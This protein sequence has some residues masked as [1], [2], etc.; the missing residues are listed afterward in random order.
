[1]SAGVV[2]ESCILHRLPG[3]VRIRLP[4]WGGSGKRSIESSL[5]AAV[6]ITGAKA[7]QTTRNV[8][9]DFDPDAIDES[10]VLALVSR[11]DTSANQ[12]GLPDESTQRDGPRPLVE[13]EAGQQRARIAVRGLEQDLR[14]ASRLVERLK[15]L[16]GVSDAIA[17]PLTGRV[18]VVFDDRQISL[19]ALRAQ[20]YEFEPDIEVEREAPEHPLDP[21]PLV[22]SASR[23]VGAAVGLAVLGLRRLA[24]AEAAAAGGPAVVVSS[25]ISLAEGF[26]ASRNAVRAT[27]GDNGAEVVFGGAGVVALTLS[28]GPLGLALAAATG[29]RTL[30]EL[31]GRRKGFEAYEQL[32]GEPV[33]PGQTIRLEAGVRAPLAGTIVSGQGTAIER[34]GMPVAIGPS[35]TVSAGSRMLGGPFELELRGDEPFSVVRRP[36]PATQTGPERYLR[37]V[38]RLS[39]A[40]A[41]ATMLATGS[42]A[43]AFAALIVVNPRALTTGSAGA[44]TDALARAQRSGATVIG[45]RPQRSLR[46]PDVVV[47]DSPRLV[48]TGWDL[49]EVTVPDGRLDSGDALAVASSVATAA[50]SPWGDVLS[51]AP[52]HGVSHGSFENGTAS[53][54]V[55][56]VRYTLEPVGAQALDRRQSSRPDAFVL[57]LHREGGSQPCATLVLER[58]LADGVG[59]LIASCRSY[60]VSVQL[61][62]FG[63]RPAAQAV[64][65]ALGASLCFDQNS[66]ELIRQRQAEGKRVAFV[67]DSAHAAAGFAACD[68]A[69]GVGDRASRFCARADLLASDLRTVSQ[70]IETGRRRDLAVRDAAV[71]SAASATLGMWWAAAKAPTVRAAFSVGSIPALAAVCASY[72]RLRGPSGSQAQAA[73]EAS[74]PRPERWGRMSVQGVVATLE[75]NEGGLTSAEAQA[76]EHIEPFRG[77]EPGLGRA[78]MGQLRSPATAVLGA[79]AALSLALGSTADV[80]MVGAVILANACVEAWQ[81][82]Q[83]NEASQTLEQLG[84]A[85]AR[86]LRDGEAVMLPKEQVVCGDVLLLAPGDHITADARLLAC[87][88]LE[89]DEAA[90][91]GEALPVAKAVDGKSDESRIVLDGSDVT[92]GT[93][94]AIAVGVGRDTRMGSIAQALAREGSTQSP[95]AAHLGRMLWQGLPLVAAAGA[96]VCVSGLLWGQP[97]L[98]QVSIGA[99]IAVAAVPEGL[100]LL[101]RVAEAGVARRLARRRALVRR[102]PVVEA[103]GRVDVAC[104]DKTGTLTTGRLELTAV[105]DLE[106]QGRLAEELEPSLRHVLETAAVA[107]PHPDALEASSHPTDVAVLRGVTAAGLGESARTVRISE[108]AF[109][110]GRAFHAALTAERLC[111]KGATESLVERCSHVRRRGAE[112]ALDEAARSELFERSQRLA[113]QGMRVLM[114]AEGTTDTDPVDPQELVA[115]GFIAISDPLRP[116]VD[117]AVARCKAA[118]VRLIMLT[119]D[120]PATARAIATQAGLTRGSQIDILT[121]P[122]VAELDTDELDRRL[123]YAAVVAR[124]TPVDKVRIVESL[125]RRGHA[126]AMTGDGVNDGPALRLADVGVAMGRGTEVAR[127]ASDVVLA[128]DDF[129]TLVEALVEGRG[130]SRNLRGALSL[131]LGGNLGE[132][133]LM[134]GAGLFG[135]PSPLTARQVLAVNLVTDVLPATA[136]AIQPPEHRNL[137]ALSRETATGFDGRMRREIV[138]RGIATAVPALATYVLTLPAGVPSARS[139]AFVSVVCNQLALTLDAGRGDQGLS[140]PVVG[141]VAGTAGLLAAGLTIVPVRTFFGFGPLGPSS[142]VLVSASAVASFLIGRLLASRNGAQALAVADA[143]AVRAGTA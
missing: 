11:L 84:S 53:A 101:A 58:R 64:A 57:A 30:T 112:L 134:V 72:L 16:P 96:A 121:G 92:V 123:E 91:T 74:D 113:E 87:E 80:V 12:P 111:V 103:L 36:A 97:L 13:S 129:S 139:A 138:H 48:T 19:E 47:L 136:V 109:E 137:A 39:L 106:H 70:L 33:E 35:Q 28:G 110:P 120:H 78:L 104:A 63:H 89:V 20:L 124:I 38:T 41:A 133:G 52:R 31:Q 23:S 21:V 4:G 115:L 143:K 6:G 131:L 49:A 18:E 29:L 98:A 42:V 122:E 130:F 22:R 85:T 69:I 8:L 118:G 88:G 24:G 60:G 140:R 73:V 32:A 99:S 81:E 1:M 56:G 14:L 37:I 125:Q 82:R 67:S 107:S 59:E 3:R 100:P 54:R 119:G 44:D 46:L 61:L 43:R 34:D 2:D 114:V 86:V 128:D 62:A 27:V 83:A 141:A 142:L 126:V 102:L 65:D 75:S 77:D 7:N 66:V 55:D 132:V 95:L 17:D 9:V 10:K 76:R 15:R 5:C 116:G 108:W 117:Q 71:L 135:M 68:L 90:L 94:R 127:Q 93:G 105:C 40:Y 26:P 79:G 45:T 25:V 50:G 51:A